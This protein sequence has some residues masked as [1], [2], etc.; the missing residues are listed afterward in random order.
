MNLTQEYF[1]EVLPATEWCS[2]QAMELLA[3]VFEIRICPAG[4]RAGFVPEV[5]A[6]AI[7]KRQQARN[8]QMPSTV[9]EARAQEFLSCGTTYVVTPHVEKAGTCE[10]IAIPGVE[11]PKGD[12]VF[13]SIRAWINEEDLP[14]HKV[15]FYVA[16][17]EFQTFQTELEELVRLTVT[18]YFIRVRCRG[19][20]QDQLPPFLVIKFLVENLNL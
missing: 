6:Q 2:T 18:P 3:N 15:A 19:R 4:I 1:I 10:T 20:K 13:D 14:R 5:E 12:P 17:A 16:L 7:Q 8:P 11:I 9:A